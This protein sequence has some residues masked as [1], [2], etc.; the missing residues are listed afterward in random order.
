MSKGTRKSLATS[1]NFSYERWIDSIED[2]K[3]SFEHAAK[4]WPKIELFS[5][6]S[7]GGDEYFRA[8][9][10]G[11]F[12][13]K[14]VANGEPITFFSFESFSYTKELSK[15]SIVNEGHWRL[16]DC[17][18]WVGKGIYA[19]G[20]T[21]ID[22]GKWGGFAGACR[23]SNNKAVCNAEIIFVEVDCQKVMEKQ[24]SFRIG[25]FLRA[26]KDI[27]EETEIIFHTHDKVV[28]HK[29]LVDFFDSQYIF[30]FGQPVSIPGK[31]AGIEY[32]SSFTAKKK[33]AVFGEELELR[34]IMDCFCSSRK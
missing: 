17:D 27:D 8:T 5:G 9:A 7:F 2:F 13:K 10:K 24:F 31:T 34:S 28:H 22:V 30:G 18:D 29:I 19:V 21:M 3:K 6:K 14:K 26:S 32:Y 4:F 20:K 23:K 1:E 33:F 25:A 11:L 12:A 15:G 16:S